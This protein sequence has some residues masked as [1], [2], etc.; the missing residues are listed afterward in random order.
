MSNIAVSIVMPI[1]NASDY[2]DK[3]L[4]GLVRQTL[5]NIEIICVNDGSKDNSLDIIKR[6]AYQDSR[7]KIIDK[8]NSGY[9]NTMNEGIN[10]AT[11]EYIGIL[12]P[13]DFCDNIMMER[14]YT[15]AKKY[16]ADVVKSNYYEYSQVNQTNTFIEVLD[17]LEYGK[18]TSAEEN[19]NIVFRRPCI[20]S[21][22][23]R[24]A[25]LKN[26]YIRFNETPGA[27]YQDTAFA[28]K[29]WVSSQRV[30]FIKDAFLHYR[31]DN[32]N[33]SVN[34][35]GKIFS[36]CDEFQSMQAF[37][38]A[39]KRLKDKYS[40]ILQVLKLDSYTWNMNRIAPEF[41]NIFKDQIALEFIKADYEGS[42]DKALFD[43]VRWSNLQNFIR[44]YKSNTND[45]SDYVQKL[46]KRIQDL[47]TSNSYKI[48]HA[49]MVIPGTIL[50]KL[51]I[52]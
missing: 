45:D 7:I 33:S 49:M 23:Y 50:R 44:K 28:F 51:K 11:G 47:E 24:T 12:E 35:S 25:V 36:I 32:E 10:I 15:T 48:G 38:N 42:L 2:L 22:I 4:G 43:E 1:Y 3:S 40:K 20:W 5:K 18:V 37:L 13:D 17:G 34:S 26:N 39:D 8:A 52:K 21:A 27:S 6:Y 16:G 30:V 19:V 31:I 41:K 14:L 46:K 9:G 29:V